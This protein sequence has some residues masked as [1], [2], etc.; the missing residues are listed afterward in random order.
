M[1]HKE[2]QSTDS[3]NTSAAAGVTYKGE[4]VDVRISGPLQ[5]DVGTPMKG[6]VVPPKKT[7]AR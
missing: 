1:E 7:G 2:H 3:A 5:D 6:S 4:S